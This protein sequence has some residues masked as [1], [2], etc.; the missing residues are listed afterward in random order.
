MTF[1]IEVEAL[2]PDCN[3]Q[4]QLFP[5]FFASASDFLRLSQAMQGERCLGCSFASLRDNLLLI[6]RLVSPTKVSPHNERSVNKGNRGE[7]VAGDMT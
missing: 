3:T 4:R 1:T 6:H 5:S 7:S 2:M